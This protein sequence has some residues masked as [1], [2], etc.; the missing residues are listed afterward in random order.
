M[1]YEQLQALNPIAFRRACGVKRETFLA[2]VEV[3]N[4]DLERH[5]KRGG[6]NRLSVADQLRMTLDYWRHYRTQFDI[7]LEFGVSESTVCRPIEKVETLLL[8]SG[9]FRLPGK[10]QLQQAE[11]SWDVVVIDVTEVAIERP[12]KPAGLLQ[13]QA[14][15][16]HAQSP[17]GD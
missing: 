6:Q 1:L 13:R 2:M 7:G 15:A 12:K 14:Q 4:S 3:L 8:R 5:G 17:V 10:R 9:R 11:V 16:P